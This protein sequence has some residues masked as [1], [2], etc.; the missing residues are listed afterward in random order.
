M[1]AK[2]WVSEMLD[3]VVDRV[4]YFLDDAQSFIEAVAAPVVM[5][6]AILS[7]IFGLLMWFVWFASGEQ[8]EIYNA[9]TGKNVTQRDMFWGNGMFKILPSDIKG[10]AK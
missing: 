6:I 10:E 2:K 5:F 4:R 8:A 3:G 1:K 9:T 7:V